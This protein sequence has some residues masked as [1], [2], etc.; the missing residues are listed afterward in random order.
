MMSSYVDKILAPG[1]GVVASGK[2]TNVIWAWPIA[3]TLASVGILFPILL[4][5]FMK[6]KTTDLVVTD[7][8]VIAKWGLFSIRT[9]EQRIAK[10]ES[11]RIE[12]DLMGRLFNYGTIVIHGTGGASTPIPDVGDPLSFKRAIETQIEAY[13]RRDR[14]VA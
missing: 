5:P 14:D 1:E 7:R 3:V 11:I 10:I 13:E 4:V 8:R 12:Q 2:I 9:I 6:Q